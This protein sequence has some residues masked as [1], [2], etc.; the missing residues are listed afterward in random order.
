MKLS[1]TISAIS[2]FTLCTIFFG[3]QAAT[4]SNTNQSPVSSNMNTTAHSS[5]T[6]ANNNTAVV[7]NNQPPPTN[8]ASGQNTTT[9]P[10]TKQDLSNAPVLEAGNSQ[11]KPVNSSRIPLLADFD[12]I[13]NGM[14][15]PQ[16]AKIFGS[17][18]EKT[19]EFKGQDGIITTYRWK[20][21]EQTSD[22]IVQA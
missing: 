19:A 12:K 5:I 21:S 10:P 18:G 16:V 3:C 17:A 6:N 9:A 22:W 13:K 8:T 20:G 2:I 11:V 15:Y 14:P 4:S 7:I 1:L